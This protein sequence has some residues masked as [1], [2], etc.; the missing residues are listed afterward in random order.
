MLVMK[1]ITNSTMYTIPEL[2]AVLF[3]ERAFNRIVF[4]EIAFKV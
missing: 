4:N 2:Y 1:N 3:N